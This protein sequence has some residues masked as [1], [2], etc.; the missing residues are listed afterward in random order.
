MQTQVRLSPSVLLHLREHE[1][2]VA[3]R[4]SE[5]QTQDP[6]SLN[7]PGSPA[8]LPARR[9]PNARVTVHVKTALEQKSIRDGIAGTF[10]RS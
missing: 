9:A 1:T 8:V 7:H 4:T 2:F 5:T 3:L 6:G 10:K